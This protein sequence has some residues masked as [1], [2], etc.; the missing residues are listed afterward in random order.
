LKT[1]Q[2]AFWREGDMIVQVWT[3]K[4]LVRMKSM[5]YG[6]ALVNTGR[7]DKTDLEIKKPHIL[8]NA[9]YS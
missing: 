3:D 2:S 5:I 8:F 4:R 1:G 9:V 7:K 6:A